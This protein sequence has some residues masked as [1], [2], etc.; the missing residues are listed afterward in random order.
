MKT[1][2]TFYL[3]LCAFAFNLNA[4]TIITVD[5]TPGAVADWNDLSSAISNAPNNAIIYVHASGTSY[6]DITINKP[7]TLI[8]YAHS[9][10][11][12]TF[13]DD[14]IIRDNTSNTTISGFDI[15]GS[16]YFN[17]SD[18]VSNFVIENNSFN[19]ITRDTILFNSGQVDN[20]LIRGN[21]LDNVG[22]ISNSKSRNNFSNTIISNNVILD[23]IF[24][25][26]HESITIENNIF[27]GL[28]ARVFNVSPETG[29]LIVKDC[30]LVVIDNSNFYS[31]NNEGVVF[32]NCLSYN[33]RNTVEDLQGSNN[34]NDTDPQFVNVTGSVF[35]PAFDFNL[36]STSPA[37][38]S[39]VDGDHM[40]LFSNKTSFIFNNFGFTQGIPT[41]KISDITSQVASG[42]NIGVTID[43]KSN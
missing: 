10:D 21:I 2:I 28:S 31:P 26:L 23:D 18:L 38:G 20:V 17:N 7:L 24:I 25:R 9:A 40:G 42:S 32:N 11:N 34:I 41:V 43:F 13:I 30:L 5:N 27:L 36:T 8:G 19:D 16:I 22:D 15:S 35:N 3:F 14:V 6:G 29:N 1:K 39:G 33:N 37:I 12:N 4:Q